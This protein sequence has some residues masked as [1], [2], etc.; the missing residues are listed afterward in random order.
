MEGWKDGR[1]EGKGKG[2]SL[3]GERGEDRQRQVRWG[4]GGEA[5][6]GGFVNT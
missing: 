1:T 4:F 2:W 5:E 6:G 3:R